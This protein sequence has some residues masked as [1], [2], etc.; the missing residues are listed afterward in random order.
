L[1]LTNTLHT[2]DHCCI[3]KPSFVTIYREEKFLEGDWGCAGD[4]V[5][6]QHLLMAIQ[7]VLHFRCTW[8]TEGDNLQENSDFECDDLKSNLEGSVNQILI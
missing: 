3:I 2:S 5:D 7:V 1:I 8:C 6:V 4:I